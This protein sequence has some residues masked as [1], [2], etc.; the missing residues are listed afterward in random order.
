M[1]RMIVALATLG[2]VV[3][4]SVFAACKQGKGDRCQTSSDC[5][6]GLI[7]SSA[8]GTC[9]GSGAMDEIDAVVPPMDV[10]KL[11]GPP[12]STPDSSTPSD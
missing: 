2:V 5:D 6:N 11:D 12:D 3:G 1:K 7:C 10:I 8:T 4:L 9:V